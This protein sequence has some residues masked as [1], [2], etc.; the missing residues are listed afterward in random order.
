MPV[1]LNQ[2]HEVVAGRWANTTP[3]GSPSSTASPQRAQRSPTSNTEW[4]RVS[5]QTPPNAALLI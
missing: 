3:A 5:C 2:V 1:S 4:T